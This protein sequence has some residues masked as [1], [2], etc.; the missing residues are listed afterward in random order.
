MQNTIRSIHDEVIVLSDNS[1]W[2]VH[3]SVSHLAGWAP[4]DPIELSGPKG[5]A[6]MT[7]LRTK[8]SVTVCAPRLARE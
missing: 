1:L 6:K 2:E 7:N 8:D 3:N 5:W 4:T